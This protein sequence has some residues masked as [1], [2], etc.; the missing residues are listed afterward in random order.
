VI[1][2]FLV[3]A[4]LGVPIGVRPGYYRGAAAYAERLPQ[5]MRSIPGRCG[6][7]R[8]RSGN[9]TSAGCCS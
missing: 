2:G 8:S 6:N 1:G 4:D 7:F 5:T 3:G 9:A